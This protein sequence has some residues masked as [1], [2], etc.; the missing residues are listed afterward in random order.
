MPGIAG[1][2]PKFLIFSVDTEPDDAR[3]EGLKDGPWSHENLSGL[4]ELQRRLNALGAR[5]TYL[6]SHSVAEQGRLEATLAADL[7]S[8]ACEAGTHFHPGD[9]PPFAKAMTK[10]GTAGY[11]NGKWQGKGRGKGRSAGDNILRQPADILEAKFAA[12]HALITARFGKPA[13]HR[14][15]AWALDARVTALLVRYGYR[16]DSSVTPGVSWKRN[17]RPSYLAA[18]MSAYPLGSGDPAAPAYPDDSAG[19]G[20][21]GNVR[22]TGILEVPVSIWSPRRW[23]GTWA[24]AIFGDILTMPL[25]A[26]GGLAVRLVRALRPAPPRWLRPA[27]MEAAEMIE[28]ADR[29]EADGAD[30][31][32]VMCHSNELWPGTSPYCRN[33]E[34]LDRFYARLE[35]LLKTA[36][37][38]GYRPVTLAGYAAELRKGNQSGIGSGNNAAGTGGPQGIAGFRAG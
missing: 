30:Y 36:L 32:H 6:I 11:G 8:G 14:A 9:T 1:P 31:L 37:E 13:S 24:G 25:A 35:G 16:V 33:R 17:G 2:R 26:R 20:T 34:E 4:P 12:L 19:P 3:W 18:P 15:G 27:F 21:Q 22:D 5:A 7:A 23:N 38:R 28:V 29:L 10:A